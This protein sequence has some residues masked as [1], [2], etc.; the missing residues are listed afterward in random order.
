MGRLLTPPFPTRLLVDLPNW[1]GDQALALP[2][3]GRLVAA[4]R[5]GETTF[6]TRPRAR[7]VYELA[8]APCRVI[9]SP[10]KAFPVASALAA[11]RGAGRFDVGITFRHA[12]RAKIF[13]RLA[14]RRAVGSAGGGSRL[15]L[16][17]SAPVD[18]RRHQVHDGD[19]L[20]ALLGL[21]ASPEWSY[22]PFPPVLE[23]EGAELLTR[24]GAHGQGVIGIAPGA[25]SGEAK[26]WP[27]E[28][29]GELVRRLDALGR[30]SV[31]VLGPGED[32]LAEAV[33]SAAGRPV[34]VVGLEA[35]VAGLAGVLSRLGLLVGNDSGPVHL[36]AWTRT[37]VTA[38]FGPTDPARTSPL[39][40]RCRVVVAPPSPAGRRALDQLAVDEV[41][42]MV[43]GVAADVGA[44]S[45]RC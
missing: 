40:E 27:P 11:C 25:A 4:N 23:D 41:L 20:L 9:T 5:G 30:H 34:P 22:P 35:D 3:V 43:L 29:Y 12:P 33:R 45:G 26:R 28:R 8:F 44:C 18:R 42:A 31:L 36:A 17:A 24:A 37:P 6:H 16:D 14:S 15:L 39:A 13:L 32:A 21:P 1:V 7:R 19:G 10:P 38:L 2:A